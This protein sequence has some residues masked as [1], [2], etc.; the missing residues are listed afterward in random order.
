MFKVSVE[1]FGV[2]VKLIKSGKRFKPLDGFDHDKSSFYENDDDDDSGIDS[3]DKDN[4]DHVEVE[5]ED[6]KEAK[7]KSRKDAKKLLRV[8]NKRQIVS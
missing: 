5:V 8:L 2:H 3:Y 7:K 6:K 1:K 4:K